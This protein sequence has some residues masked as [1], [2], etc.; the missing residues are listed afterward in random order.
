[1]KAYCKY[2]RELNSQILYL[3][4]LTIPISV[5]VTQELIME[6]M[7]VSYVM[8]KYYIRIEYIHANLETV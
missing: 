7:I 1:M 4:D 5:E 6:Q 3:H 2:N 8:Y